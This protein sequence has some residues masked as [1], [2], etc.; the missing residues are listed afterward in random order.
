MHASQTSQPGMG[1]FQFRIRSL[2]ALMLLVSLVLGVFFGPFSKRIFQEIQPV[3][4]DMVGTT[5]GE[6]KKSRGDNGQRIVEC[7]IFFYSEEQFGIRI[8]AGPPGNLAE[9]ADIALGSAMSRPQWIGHNA[10]LA[11][12]FV[13]EENRLTIL[14]C[15][16]SR[17]AAICQMSFPDRSYDELERFLET[18]SGGLAKRA[19]GLDVGFCFKT[20]GDAR[21]AGQSLCLELYSDPTSDN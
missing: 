21:P 20:G 9:A 1:R 8:F 16:D 5:T 11:T 4:E 17:A 3:T 14:D 12:R 6:I 7:D 18:L 15:S 10:I 2:L 19:L 13:V